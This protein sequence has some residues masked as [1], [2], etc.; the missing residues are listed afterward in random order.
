MRSRRQIVVVATV[1]LLG[2]SGCS[3]TADDPASPASSAT[4]TVVSPSPV[5]SPTPD[6]D[7]S[8]AEAMRIIRRAY[9]L[10]LSA[11]ADGV[12]EYPVELTEILADPY[13]SWS[14]AGVKEY[15]ELG[16]TPPPDEVPVI[17]LRESP[18]VSM[19][20]SELAVE[21]CLQ[22]V[23]A[24]DSTGQV[25]SDAVLIRKTFFFRHLDGRMKLFTATKGEEISKCPSW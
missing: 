17:V 19:D 23:A 4:P 6:M 16:W 18:G 21:G 15:H 20:G 7:A 22:G 11:M 12:D 14:A 25:A 13:L 2:L 24:L 1:V 10:E 9:E 5:A 3:D 8:Y